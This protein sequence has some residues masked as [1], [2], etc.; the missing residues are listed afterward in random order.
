MI[1]GAASA[2]TKA[3]SSLDRNLNERGYKTFV[4]DSPATSAT[5]APPASAPNWDFRVV[6]EAW[7]DNGAFGAAGYGD[8]KLTFVH[9]SPSKASSNTL[10][11]VPGP[12]PPDWMK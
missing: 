2:I 6:Y 7:I 8:V 5:Y 11:V 4:V 9:A 3:M 12:C 10:S 1:L